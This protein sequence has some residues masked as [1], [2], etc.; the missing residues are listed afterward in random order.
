LFGRVSCCRLY[1]M[2]EMMSND[3][4]FDEQI[5]N[6]FSDI[7]S[8][9]TEAHETCDV[10][11]LVVT[12]NKHVSKVVLV[13]SSLTTEF[14]RLRA[15]AEADFFRPLSCFGERY[16]D[17]P[18]PEGEE[19]SN[20]AALLPLLEDLSAF[21]QR[22]HDVV[23]NAISQ[24]AGLYGSKALREVRPQAGSEHGFDSPPL[25]L[26]LFPPCF[27][28]RSHATSPFLPHLPGGG[29]SVGR[30]CSGSCATWATS[31]TTL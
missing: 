22:C 2:L 31:S 13:F 10:S 30:T 7:I 15:I 19:S 26:P 3:T 4:C 17:G 9:H 21:V 11:D 16:D 14:V 18:I 29:A 27:F 5:W 6:P 23:A 20:I 1:T 8:V 12:D 24:L 28:P 25:Y